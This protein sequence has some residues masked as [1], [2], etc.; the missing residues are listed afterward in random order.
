MEKRYIRQTTYRGIGTEGQER[1]RSARVAVIGLGATGSRVAEMLARSGTGC[2]RL[3]DRDCVYRSNLQRMSMYTEADVLNETPKAVAAA[4]YL[5]KV[6]SEVE[7]QALYEDLNAHTVDRIL[8]DVD[9]V[10]DGT[11]NSETK[12]LIGE[13]CHHKRLPWIYSMVVGSSGR[14]QN[15]IPGDNHPCLR[16]TMS[17]DGDKD[18]PTCLT[19]GV[20]SSSAGLI[21]SAVASEALKIITGSD[22]IRKEMLYIDDWH[23]IFRKVALR[24][25][26]E[27]PVCAYGRY[28]YY[29]KASG[30]QAAALCGKDSVQIVPE[31]DDLL[32]FESIAAKLEPYGTVRINV[33]TLDFD[34]G[35][36][37][38]KLFR[39]GRAIIKNTADVNRAR[40]IYNRYIR[41]AVRA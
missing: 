31:G 22:D 12:F 21:A 35:I 7:I 19:E 17:Y 10:I 33:F 34:D 3:V 20:L 25:D 41:D 39:N 15:F 32:D 24:R 29:G 16:C 23:N 6:N 11:D 30:I 37:G 28:S 1:I 38:I 5:K 2:L 27:C 36:I 40:A 13:A 26:P 4:E 18:A 8:E 14:T 9:L